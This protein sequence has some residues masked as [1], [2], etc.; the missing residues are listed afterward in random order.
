MFPSRRRLLMVGV[1][2]SAVIIASLAYNYLPPVMARPGRE[3]TLTLHRDATGQVERIPFEEYIAGVVAAEVDPT[4]PAQVLAAQAIVAR[5][6]TWERVRRGGVR[7]LHGT[8]VCDDPQHMQAYDPT[9]VND[10]IRR[11]VRDT[12]GLIIL[13][14]GRPV[15]AYFHASSGGRTA[16]PWEGLGIR[17][18]ALPYLRSVEDPGVKE[19]RWEAKFELAELVEAVGKLAEPPSQARRV[20]VTRRG[21]SGR[22]VTIAVDG[23]EVPAHELRLALGPE[24]MRSTLLTDIRCDGNQVVIRG[25]GFGHGV[26]LSQEGAKAMAEQGSTA[27]EIIGHFYQGVRFFRLWQ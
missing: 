20:R 24:R 15:R 22:A 12:R 3:P 18:P 2:V 7:A 19:D 27:E 1:A 8:D 23:V 10:A 4:W 21:P 9:R 6:F 26:G 17:R 16:E 11:A 25:R 14:K 5:T 13:Y